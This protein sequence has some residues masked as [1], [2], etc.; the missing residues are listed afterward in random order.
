MIVS[1]SI[2]FRTR[3]AIVLPSLLQVASRINSHYDVTILFPEYLFFLHCMIRASV[4]LMKV[5]CEQAKARRSENRLLAL[6]IPYLEQHIQEEMHHDEWLI[7]DLEAIGRSREELLSRMPPI[8]IASMIGAQYYW[9]HHYHPASIL[10]FIGAMEGCPPTVEFVDDL[11]ARSG[12]PR[13]AFR[14]L[15]KHAQ[16]DPLHRADLDMFLDSAPLSDCDFEI[17]DN[18]AL[19]TIIGATNAFEEL[20]VRHTWRAKM[21]V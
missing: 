5:A 1:N 20:L 10:G 15:Y 6:M 18:S 13:A 2:I 14:T 16:L 17:I 21:V 19:H 9:I 8:P 7:Q 12:L 4:P 11:R 3:S